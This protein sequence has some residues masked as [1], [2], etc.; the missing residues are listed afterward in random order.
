MFLLSLFWYYLLS[1]SSFSFSS[2]LLSWSIWF[3]TQFSISVCSLINSSCHL[4]WNCLIMLSSCL[5]LNVLMSRRLSMSKRLESL[6]SCNDL[7]IFF[8]NSMC[9]FFLSTSVL[10]IWRTISRSYNVRFSY[11]KMRIDARWENFVEFERLET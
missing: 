4:D 10:C 1:C 11:L 9:V 8:L 6:F 2:F 7:C 5:Y 3:S